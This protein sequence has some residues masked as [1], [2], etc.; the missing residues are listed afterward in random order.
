M[1]FRPSQVRVG[2]YIELTASLSVSY[3]YIV[4]AIERDGALGDRFEI[5]GRDLPGTNSEGL[6]V[7]GDEGCAWVSVYHLIHRW[8]AHWPSIEFAEA[9]YT[10]DALRKAVAAG[11]VAGLG[12]LTLVA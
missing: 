4:R 12:T 10:H 5:D 11:K 9:H 8:N 1:T 6:T 2:D 7:G 3:R